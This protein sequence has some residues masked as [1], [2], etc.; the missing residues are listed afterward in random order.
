VGASRVPVRVCVVTTT[1]YVINVFLKRHLAAL[2]DCYDVTLAV[3]AQD[4]YRLEA[5]LDPRVQVVHIGL[6]RKISPLR[7]FAALLA[8]VRLLRK[9]DFGAVHTIAPKAGLLGIVAG[10]LARVPARIHTFQGEVWASR[11]GLARAVLMRADRLMGRLLT[12]ALV[13]GRGEQAFLEQHG[14]LRAGQSTVLRQGSIGGVDTGRFHPDPDVRSRVRADLGV[15]PDD[16]AVMYLGRIARDKGVLDLA[17]AFG[18]LEGASHLVLVGADEE[19]LRRAIEEACGK[20]VE[21]LRFVP[22]NSSPERY[23]VAADVVCLPSHREGF[24][25]TLIEAG[26]CGV[27]VVAARLY[28]TQ[29]AVVDGVTGLFHVPGDAAE[30]AQRLR[31]LAHDPVLRER[32]GTA[33]RERVQRDFRS[34]DLIR[35]F[36]DYYAAVLGPGRCA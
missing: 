11:R 33:G 27:P 4:A 9:G 35:A 1:P 30:L 22:F 28:G 29:D 20:R 8:L 26:A 25:M 10:Y 24:G 36:R 3:N 15:G 14:V 5:G 2:A 7:D 34:E 16:F 32:L 19:G 17:R 6:E 12:H 21:R 23:M 31:T 18:E 13:V